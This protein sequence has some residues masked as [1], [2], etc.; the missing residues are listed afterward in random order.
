[1][2]PSGPPAAAIGQESPPRGQRTL[3]RGLKSLR[4]RCPRGFTLVELLVVIT[5]IGILVSLLLP[6]VQ[7]AR[8]AA[9]RVQ[10]ENNLKQLALGMH[11]YHTAHLVL[12]PGA[13]T[14]VGEYVGKRQGPGEW[15]D[16]HGWY[17]QIGAQIDQ[18]NWFQL[19]NFKISFSD[20]AND[21]PRRLMMSVFSCPDDG[22]RR[23]EWDSNTWRG[24]AATTSSTSATRITAKRRK[25]A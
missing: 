9:R 5:I 21:P 25:R 24:S 23:N 1:M 3:G 18:I 20:P 10:C 6:A 4:G 7:G 12:P 19:I 22:L 8:E 16:D 11:S 17:S 15:Y 2:L 14:W 13:L